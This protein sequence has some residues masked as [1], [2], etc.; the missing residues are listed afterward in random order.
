VTTQLRR[1]PKFTEERFWALVDKTGSCWVWTGSV[2]ATTGYGR[3]GSMGASTH[4][5]SWSLLRGPVPEGLQLDHLCRVRICCNPD[6]L[7][8]VTPRENLMRGQTL[9]AANAAKTHCS[10]GHEYSDT[11]THVSPQRRRKCRICM[12]AAS[13][14][15][16]VL[17]LSRLRQNPTDKEQGGA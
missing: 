17:R 14:D 5:I 13:K 8:P 9:A 16:Y 6:H 2:N 7:E 3:A 12:A 10:R 4:A 11:N 15:A 1:R